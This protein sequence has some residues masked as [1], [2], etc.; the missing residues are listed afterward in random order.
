MKQIR[1]LSPHLNCEETYIKL[2][3]PFICD[4]CEYAIC[5][6]FYMDMECYLITDRI[7]AA[8][9]ALLRFAIVNEYDIVS[10][11]PV[12]EELYYNLKYGFID[13]IY[14]T[15]SH[16][17]RINIDVP[18]ISRLDSSCKNIVATGISCGVDSL[19]TVWNHLH[20]NDHTLTHLMYF[21]IGAH[22][23]NELA[24]Q[25]KELAI[26]FSKEVNLP[27]IIV[28]SNLP[29]L[30]T[31]IQGRA[32]N[33]LVYHTYMMASIILCMQSAIKYYF[34]SSTYSFDHFNLSLY[35]DCAKYDLFSL[36]TFSINGTKIISAGGAVSRIDKVKSI[37]SFPLSY[38]YLNV[39]IANIKNDCLCFKCIRTLL[40]LDAI[41]VLDRYSAV[42]DVEF[43]KKNRKY[44]LY[45]L[46]YRSR[47]IK[48][49]YLTSE[50]YDYFKNELTPVFKIKAILHL[51]INRLL[52]RRKL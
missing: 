31:E 29:N 8:L 44:Y 1:I 35:D 6:K 23:T 42:F 20:N 34:Y 24:Q 49:D 48:D 16:L 39:C 15:N 4:G 52:K 45:R 41:G 40:E 26:N 17:R 7:D 21:D 37:S 5:N 13:S 27:L 18:L 11:I 33:H 25:R 51:T 30:L 38:K 2:E 9:V 3:V 10:D 28:D 43:Y 46:Y 19:Y 50:I 22:L 12:S 47:F 36:N 14:S 32:Y